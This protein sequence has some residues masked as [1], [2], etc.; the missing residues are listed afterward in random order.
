MSRGPTAIALAALA[1]ALLGAESASACSC[2]PPKPRELLREMDGAIIGR[3][4]AVRPVEPRDPGEPRSTADP[5]N[6]VYRVGRVFNDGP[7]LDRGRRVRVRSVRSEVSCGLP[8]GRGELFGLFLDREGGRWTSGLCLVVSP[9]QMRR[10]AE[11]ESSA[12]LA[13]GLAAPRLA[14][15]LEG[16]EGDQQCDDRVQEPGAEQ[17]VA[18][19]ADQ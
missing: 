10:A 9:K 14:A 12:A 18:E 1:I 8:R 16:D 4:L 11:A 17:G 2:V 13:A 7:G 5:V 19:Q 3:L 6:F 15:F